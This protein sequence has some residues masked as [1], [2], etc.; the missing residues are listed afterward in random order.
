M[1]LNQCSYQTEGNSVFK[2]SHLRACCIPPLEFG[3]KESITSLLTT[4]AP[5]KMTTTCLSTHMT[6]DRC[7]YFCSLLLTLIIR[8]WHTLTCSNPCGFLLNWLYSLQN[9]VCHEEI[10]IYYLGA[11]PFVWDCVVTWPTSGCSFPTAVFWDRFI[12]RRMLWF[13]ACGLEKSKVGGKK[14]N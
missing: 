5:R 12:P 13:W 9:M 11:H 2:Q 14:I 1:Q 3:S 7:S 10:E 8:F 4:Y 6:K